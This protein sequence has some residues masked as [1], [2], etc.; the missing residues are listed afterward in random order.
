MHKKLLPNVLIQLS[1]L[2]FNAKVKLLTGNDINITV[3]KNKCVFPLF[4]VPIYYM[5]NDSR[6]TAP[7]SS[8]QQKLHYL[9][10]LSVCIYVSLRKKSFNEIFFNV[11]LNYFATLPRSSEVISLFCPFDIM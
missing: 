6:M 10:Y 5:P 7:P 4:G 3:N 2:L 8:T 9:N 1:I 11:F